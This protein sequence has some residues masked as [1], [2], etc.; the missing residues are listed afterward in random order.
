MS[1]V[2][3]SQEEITRQNSKTTLNRRGSMSR[4]YSKREG[5]E[6]PLASPANFIKEAGGVN[7]DKIAVACPL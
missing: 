4:F 6:T 3:T 5:L 2:P 7:P 1:S